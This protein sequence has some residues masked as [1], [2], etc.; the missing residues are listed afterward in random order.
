[1]WNITY[2][3]RAQTSGAGF[4][5]VGVPDSSDA[6]LHHF[7]VSSTTTGA[8]SVGRYNWQAW[9]VNIADNTI[10]RIVRQGRVEVLK[11][12]NSLA[13][14]AQ[15]DNR[16]DARKTLDAID[17]LM[18]NKATIDQQ[19]YMIAA[20]GSQR[21]LKRIPI[22]ELLQLRKYY[23]ALVRSEQGNK[24]RTIKLQL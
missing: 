24:L 15:Y 20:G 10:K 23:A 4:D 9:A 12:L 5:A 7:T 18:A 21:M 17:A 11:G 2:Y 16:S 14:S 22:T 8:A 1:E 19:E 3:F 13:T 6:E